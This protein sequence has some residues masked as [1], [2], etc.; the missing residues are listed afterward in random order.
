MPSIVRKT[1]ISKITDQHR[2]PVCGGERES[3]EET[4]F[5]GIENTMTVATFECAAIFGAN[6]SC[7][8]NLQSCASGS[9]LAARL[10]TIEAKE[11]RGR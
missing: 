1:F 10:M 2:C 4:S 9:E 8:T 6:E 5:E 7:V 11:G 3:L